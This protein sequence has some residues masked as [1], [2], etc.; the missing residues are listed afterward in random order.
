M[1]QCA[2]ECVITNKVC[3]EKK[4]RQWIKYKKDLN[5]TLVAVNKNGRMTLEEVGKRL[6]ISYA[7]VNQIEKSA[8]KK[9]QK[10][11]LSF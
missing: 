7:R 9:L 5:C 6:S 8:V 2:K 1:R 10:K 11:V 4:C 3:G